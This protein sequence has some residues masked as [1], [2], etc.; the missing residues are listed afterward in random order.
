MS[1][2]LAVGQNNPISLAVD[3]ANVY[4]TDLAISGANGCEGGETQFTGWIM[5]VP[6]GGGMPEALVTGRDLPLLITLDDNFIYW[7]EA[8]TD[9]IAL[10]KAGGTPVT[11][12]SIKQYGIA[13]DSSH[14]FWTS[15]VAV[16]QADSGGANPVQLAGGQDGSN[17]IATDGTNV[18]WTTNATNPAP[19]LQVPVGGGTIVTLATAPPGN[20]IAVN[21]T[22]V[23]WTVSGAVLSV[24]IGGG[25]V[26]TV[27]MDETVPEDGVPDTLAA[28]DDPVYWS[29]VFQLPNGVTT[30]D[31]LKVPAAGGTITTLSSGGRPS[32]VTLDAANLYW[33]DVSNGSINVQPK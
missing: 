28:D 15:G 20:S 26:S 29:T 10:P 31:L 9:L 7:H 11:V 17:G 1:A 14:I 6:L 32:G 13:S 4:W 5:R 22:T 25:T 21:S 2:V 19:V 27:A 24:P 3:E 18:Y 16:M 30:G 33:V 23:F 8:G 12:N